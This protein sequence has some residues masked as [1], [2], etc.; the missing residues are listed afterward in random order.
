MT[1]FTRVGIEAKHRNTRL[2]EPEVMLEILI[3]NTQGLL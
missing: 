1:P 2:L 3:K